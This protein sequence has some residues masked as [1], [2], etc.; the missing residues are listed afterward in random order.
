D[1]IWENLCSTYSNTFAYY[2]KHTLPASLQVPFTRW[3]SAYGDQQGLMDTI[4]DSSRDCLYPATDKCSDLWF[5]Y[6]GRKKTRTYTAGCSR[7][8]ITQDPPCHDSGGPTIKNG[9]ITFSYNNVCGANR[10]SQLL[11]T[12]DIDRASLTTTKAGT[13]AVVT[14]SAPV[15]AQQ[16]PTVSS[17]SLTTTRATATHTSSSVSQLPPTT[18]S[19]THPIT[20]STIKTTSP[21]STTSTSTI[22]TTSP[23]STTSTSTI[24]TGSTNTIITGTSSKAASSSFQSYKSSTT[25]AVLASNSASKPDSLVS[26]S[27]TKSLPLSTSAAYVSSA[28]T[29]SSRTYIASSSLDLDEE[30]TRSSSRP[31]ATSNVQPFARPTDALSNT[32]ESDFKTRTIVNLSST[33][34]SSLTTKSSSITSPLS[35]ATSSSKVIVSSTSKFSSV[36]TIVAV[37][38]TTKSSAPATATNTLTKGNSTMA[39]SLSKNEV[40]VERPFTWSTYFAAMFLPALVAVVIKVTWEVI[41]TSLKLIEPFERLAKGNGATAS[42]SILTEYLEGMISSDILQALGHGRT[43]PIISALIYIM[44]GVA[45]LIAS[46]SMSV[47]PRKM[48]LDDENQYRPCDPAWVINIPL[49]RLLEG[50]VLA[51]IALVLCLMW[52]T[53]RSRIPLATNPSSI[54]SLATL[55]NYQTLLQELQS[56]DPD[57]DGRLFSAAWKK[58]LFRIVEHY[59]QKTDRTRF[60]FVTYRT[61]HAVQ[62]EDRSSWLSFSTSSKTSRISYTSIDDNPDDAGRV[63]PSSS[64]QFRRYSYAWTLTSLHLLTTTALLTIILTYWLDQNLDDAFNRFFNADSV[65]AIVPKTL[66]VGLAVLVDMQMKHLDRVVRI[67]DPFRRLASRNARAETTIL[68]PLNGTCWSNLPRNLYLL[69]RYEF[70]EGRMWWVT[71]VS[72]VACLSD[73]NI[74]AVAGLLWNLAQTSLTY[75]L[76]GYLSMACTSAILAVVLVTMAWWLKVSVIR[77]MP[78]QPDTI[79]S[80]LSYLCGSEMVR[81]W[82]SDSTSATPMEY[83]SRKERDTLVKSSERRFCFGRML[84]VDDRERWCIDYER[85]QG[86]VMIENDIEPGNSATASSMRGKWQP[87]P[88]HTIPRKPLARELGSE[89]A[90]MG[91]DQSS[92]GWSRFP[93]LRASRSHER[94]QLNEYD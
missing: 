68:L 82:N 47:K 19:T 32:Y 16:T 53:R 42:Y 63:K 83:L 90:L 35:N 66:L 78:R 12:T 84:G 73:L 87:A 40:I 94:Q 38:T 60:G 52:L 72:L 67:T 3:M 65:P 14:T 92:D 56:I 58:K 17:A 7:G 28:A 89:S 61:K 49:I 70:A 29:S 85:D 80:M 20:T 15:T 86:H 81:D 69:F 6:N 8:I 71:V 54:A 57:A 1:S 75:H 50:F 93:S 33:S 48:C 62:N 34:T 31:T 10:V 64:F 4:K 88:T 11:I 46:V 2:T 91:S 36:S 27:D 77:R 74:I 22:K 25:S 13:K 51:C 5:M 30:T 23:V 26:K 45:P 24:R 59:D 79:G 44:V 76:C 9:T 41:A 43:I 55:L 18:P 21:V 39:F 37:G